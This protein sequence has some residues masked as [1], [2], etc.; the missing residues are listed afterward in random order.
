MT[1]P[2][3]SASVQPLRDRLDGELLLPGADGYDQG[4]A[5]WNGRFDQRP[6][7]IVRCHNAS[8]VAAAIGVAR[9]ED[10]PLSVRSGGH[11]YAGHAVAEGGLAIDLSAMNGVRI[12]P[13]R[14]LAVV[15]PGATWG[16]LDRQAQVHGL[17]TTGPTVSTVGVAGVA[18]GG[19]TGYLARKYGLVIDNL[20]AVDVV[21]ADGRVVR[22]SE[23]ENPDLFWALRGGGGNFGVA[24]SFDFRLHAVG[25]E[26]VTA[27]AFHAF[28]DARDVLHFYREFTA[29]APDEVTVYAFVLRVPPVDPFPDEHQGRPAIALVACHCG[30]VPEGQEQLRPLRDFGSPFLAVLQAQ[31]YTAA[32]QAFDAGMPKG[33]R[34]F[35]RAHY[36]SGLSDG[37]IDT[38]LDHTAALPGPF[39]MAYIEPLG[40]AIGRV[41]PTATAFPH[42]HAPYGL[43]I[44]PG[45]TDPAD[46]STLMEWARGFH[47]DMAPFATGGVYL[48]LL[49]GDEAARVP[50]AYGQNYERLRELKARWDPGNLFRVNHNI[51]PASGT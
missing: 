2:L 26:V 9:E 8:D 37:A 11:S 20:L 27:Q 17:A 4:R 47:R 25:P 16:D 39:T 13:E 43:H 33:L 30:A 32:Q 44:F 22:A 51:P 49:G 40:G 5:A 1:N 50:N 34:W 31:P 29:A 12:D 19:G 48:N 42:R 41:E 24:T 7:A 38:M 45:W 35:S 21:S 6:A 28:S 46:D 15:G 18:L 14:K 36:L 3:D 10:L 23:A